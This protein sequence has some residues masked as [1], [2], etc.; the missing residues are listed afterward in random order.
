MKEKTIYA[1][2]FFDGVHIGHQALLLACKHLAAQR[3]CKAGVV[4]FTSHPDAL[5]SGSSPALLN[6]IEDRQRILHGY[7]MDTVLVLPFDREIMTTHWASFLRQLVGAGAAGF[8]CGDDFRFGSGGLGTPKKLAAFCNKQGLPYAVVSQQ[9]LDGIRVSS[10]HI[11]DLLEKGEMA[12]ANRFL[13]H[14]HFL[15]GR[16]TEGKQLG[17][18]IGIPT[19]NLQIPEGVICPKKGVYACRVI[20]EGQVYPAVTNIGCRPT[21]GGENI[22]VEPWIL[23]FD[24]DL[25][26][27]HI[28]LLFYHFLREE[29][30]FDSLEELKA[31][32]HLDAAETFKLLR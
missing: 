5:V 17:R 3:G 6:T 12:T 32:I 19:A 16:V 7:G 9:E 14:P 1:L 26:G 21:V 20:V 18:T 30:K 23:D 13:G 11:R 29:K 24:G 2:G 25:Y 8:V 27:K 22:T 28:T 4:T 15:S 10:T 31:Q